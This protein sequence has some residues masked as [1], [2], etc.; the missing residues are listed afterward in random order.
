M[1][2]FYILRDEK[3]EASTA[4]RD[5]AIELIRLKQE[6]E[7]KAHQWL[8]AEFSIIEGE[9]EFIKY[10]DVPLDIKEQKVICERYRTRQ[11]EIKYFKQLAYEFERDGHRNN[12]DPVMMAKAESYRLAA[13][14]LEH[15][16]KE[17][18]DK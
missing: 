3:I 1:K 11:E 13:F 2:R 16:T 12:D 15:N 9:Q 17:G 4:T 10:E 5:E 14:D 6:M 18:W 7:K 8:H